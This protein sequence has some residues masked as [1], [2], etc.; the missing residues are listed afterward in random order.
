MRDVSFKNHTLRTAVAEATLIASPITL[1]KILAGQIPKGD[2]LPIAKVAAVQAAKKTTEWIPYCHNIPIEFVGVDFDLQE[3][4]I[5]V[6]VTVKTVAK[7][8]VEMEAMTAASAAVLTLYD[9]LKMLDEEMEIVNVK[10][11]EKRGGKS[12]FALKGSPSV[13][14]LVVSDRASAGEYE[15]VS[16][17]VLVS[18]ITKYGIEDIQKRIVSDDAAAIQAACRDWIAA[19]VDFVLVTGGTGVGPRDGTPEALSGVI[20]RSLPGVVEWLRQYSQ[21]RIS[22]G[23][24]SRSVAGI[25]GRTVIVA[26]PGSPGACEDAICALLP[27]LF[28]AREMLDGGAHS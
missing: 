24:L 22:T 26:L 2:P 10:L 14:V 12:D 1:E 4:K 25:A 15:D 28:H 19:S 16:G 11:L 5:V 17:E 18:G 6:T 21:L 23:F 9:M 7:T 8:G 27:G 13:R 3:R 20:E